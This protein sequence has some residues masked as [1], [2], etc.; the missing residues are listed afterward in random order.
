MSQRLPVISG[1]FVSPVAVDRDLTLQAYCDASGIFAGRYQ[2]IGIV[3][4]NT[5]S[6][7][8]LREV[9]INSLESNSIREIRFA[10]V[11][12]QGSR[13]D[14]T[15][16][17]FI[18]STIDQFIAVGLIRVDVLSWYTAD[19]RHSVP[20]R[21]DSENLGRLYYHLLHSI[22]QRWPRGYWEVIIDKDE[23][24][25]FDTLKDCINNKLLQSTNIPTLDLVTSAPQIEE[26]GAVSDIREAESEEEP[27][28]QLAD[29]FA[30]TA[31]FSHDKGTQCCDWVVTYG[32]PA[33]P[34]L[35]DPFAQL[36][37]QDYGKSDTCRFQLIAEL[38]TVCKKH[39]LAVS[40]N[41]KKHLW[42]RNPAHPINF[43]TY[44]PQ[45]KYDRAPVRRQ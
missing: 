30:G 3:S 10:A 43:W 20:G 31:R 17:Q 6:L 34:P 1:R 40:L 38:C 19:S 12:R 26:L 21:D 25:S 45:S 41:E 18:L 13:E 22:T 28:V 24:V 35:P 27:L 33:Q 5:A 16:R 7:E 11:R 23:R 32:N 2:S 44:E 36:R 29:L 14:R 9:L 8:R 39:R 15:A 42:T 37:V 4:G